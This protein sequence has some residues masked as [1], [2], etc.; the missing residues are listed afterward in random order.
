M[1]GRIIAWLIIGIIGIPL[2]LFFGTALIL[3][4]APGFELFGVRYVTKGIVDFKETKIVDNF[5]GEI[6]INTYD[7]PVV[8]EYAPIPNVQVTFRQEFVGFTTTKAK[9]PD[10]R[11]SIDDAGNAIISTVEIQKF[12]FASKLED[13]YYFTILVPDAGKNIH[14]KAETSS[15]TFQGSNGYAPRVGI[16]SQG[17]LSVKNQLKVGTLNYTTNSDVDLTANLQLTNATIKTGN[18]Y[19]SI[20]NAVDGDLNLTNTSGNISFNQCNN[21]TVSTSSGVVKSSV[22]NGAIVKGKAKITTRSGSIN[23]NKVEGTADKS[24]ITTKTGAVNIGSIHDL[25]IESSRGDINIVQVRN[26]EIEGGAGDISIKGVSGSAKINTTNGKVVLGENKDGGGS[27]YNPTVN[28]TTGKIYAYN[29]VGDK[30]YLKSTNN[31]VYVK[32]TKGLGSDN[33]YLHAGRELTAKNLEGK[34]E[35]YANGEV[36]LHFQ[37]LTENVKVSVGAKCRKVKLDAKC[38]VYSEVNYNIKSTKN[39]VIKLYAEDSNVVTKNGSLKSTN[40]VAAPTITITGAYQ[41]TYLYLKKT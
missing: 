2:L 35:A 27:I 8:V 34:V 12:I 20:K 21:L 23:L 17:K 33:F 10:L 16:E 1:K 24:V 41:E 30:V 6:Y 36:N 11:V 25:K 40:L 29:V 26:I 9:T 15:V 39:K 18:K 5:R 32:N 31:L 37:S 38:K 28:T 14:V 3:F 7:V 19:I 4:L 22:S 13:N